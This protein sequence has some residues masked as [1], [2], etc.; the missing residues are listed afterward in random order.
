[1]SRASRNISVKLNPSL[2]NIKTDPLRDL[3]TET[4][5]QQHTGFGSGV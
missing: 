1:M 2:A 5:L 3:K 4:Q